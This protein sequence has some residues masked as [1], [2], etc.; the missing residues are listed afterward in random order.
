MKQLSVM[1]KP[2]SSL[3]NMRCQYCFYANITNLREVASF[4][5]MEPGI[6]EKVIENIYA[7]LEPGDRLILAFQGGEPTMAG[8]AY[9]RH[10]VRTAEAGKKKVHVEYA[11]QT[12]GL[13]L[14]DE[15][16]EFLAEHRF[17]V[18]VS[19]DILPENHDAVRLDS[20]GAGTYQRVLKS[21]RLLERHHVDYNVLCTLTNQVARHPRKVWN[22][23][24][25]LDLKYVQFTPCL[26]ELDRPGESAYALTPARFSG[27]Y[28]EIFDLWY[29]EFREGRYRSIKL[30]DDVIQLMAHGIE[31]ACGICG[32]C[33]P[34]IIVEADGGTYPCDFYCLDEYRLG[35]L[36]ETT[37]REIYERSAA[38][39]SK[40][41]GPLPALC[42]EC[43][44]IRLCGGGCKRMQREV[45]CE[46]GD[47]F[48]G[49][50]DFLYYAVGRMQEIARLQRR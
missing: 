18:G 40:R 17:L 9:F 29:Q 13:L 5:I 35:N 3:C 2:A 46:E 37:I 16:C 33:Q 39:P 25:K 10:F 26:D 27:F 7:D 22:Q 38:S 36:T 14:D 20:K 15:W 31:T 41:R 6:T 43:P 34:Q 44:F 19:L 47:S 30:F 24:M 12:N 48:C 4:G 11:L 32:R 8:L 1:I 21:I 42:R 49:Y 50:Q 23:I 45:C 28:K